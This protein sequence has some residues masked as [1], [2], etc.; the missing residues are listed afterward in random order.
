M[1]DMAAITSNLLLKTNDNVLK[2]PPDQSMSMKSAEIHVL[3]MDEE[4]QGGEEDEKDS[5]V[6]LIA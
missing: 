1:Y 6:E 4:K 2:T 3:I 5:K